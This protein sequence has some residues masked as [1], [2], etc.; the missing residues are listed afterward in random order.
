MRRGAKP[1][2]RRGG[3]KKGTPNKATAARRAEYAKA[4]VMPIDYWLAILRD[5]NETNERRERAAHEVAPYVERR[6][7]QAIEGPSED[8]V[9][10]IRTVE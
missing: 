3:R 4:G 8:G 7:P 9:I 10:E 6:M 5:T 2:E 1:G